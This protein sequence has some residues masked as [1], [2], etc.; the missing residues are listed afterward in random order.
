MCHAFA[1]WR[2]FSRLTI[3]GH[4]MFRGRTLGGQPVFNVLL[5]L[6]SVSFL[7]GGDVEF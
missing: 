1:V 5:P 7:L 3:A 4:R 2:S 6:C